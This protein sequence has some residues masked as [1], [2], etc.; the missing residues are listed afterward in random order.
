MIQFL[1]W[2]LAFLL[3]TSSCQIVRMAGKQRASKEWVDADNPISDWIVS[4]MLLVFFG[5]C[6]WRC[7]TNALGA[8]Q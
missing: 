8:G 2:A 6:I 7:V 5:A 4:L 3:F 1:D